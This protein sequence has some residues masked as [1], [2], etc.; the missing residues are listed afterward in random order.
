V[1]QKKIAHSIV[2]LIM[3]MLLVGCGAYTKPPS[4]PPATAP[5]LAF[6]VNSISNTISSYTVDPQ[7]GQLIAKET[8]PT[9]A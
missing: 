6:V 8:V 2:I 9:A 7:T 4:T 3:P 5:R 1:S